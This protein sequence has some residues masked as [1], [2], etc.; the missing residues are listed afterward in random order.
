MFT[1]G[2]VIKIKYSNCK[3][4]KLITITY[5]INNVFFFNELK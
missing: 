1:K 3:Y 4:F 5:F 2:C